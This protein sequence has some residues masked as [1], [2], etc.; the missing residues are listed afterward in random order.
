MLIW[1]K[2]YHCTDRLQADRVC[3]LLDK[4]NI[5]YKVSSPEAVGQ[6]FITGSATS[7]M[8]LKNPAHSSMTNMV[9]N[10]YAGGF[11]FKVHR[12]DL[13]RARELESFKDLP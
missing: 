10:S 7:G 3:E 5:R 11:T 9:S 6:N 13:E 8:S 12:A 2:F 1:K 4:E